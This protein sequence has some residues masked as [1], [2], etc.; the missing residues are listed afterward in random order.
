[1]GLGISS[2][3]LGSRLVGSSNL[4]IQVDSKIFF[5]EKGFFGGF[6]YKVEKGAIEWGVKR[7]E[8]SALRLSEIGHKWFGSTKAL[9]KILYVRLEI[10]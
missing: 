9:P 10:N 4:G 5:G 2:I 8:C 7:V 1:M 3:N 6:R